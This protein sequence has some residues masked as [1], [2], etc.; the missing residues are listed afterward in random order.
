ML[1]LAF[2]ASGFQLF[3]GG[4]AVLGWLVASLA[5]AEYLRHESRRGQF[6]TF[7]VLTLLAV[8]GVFLAADFLTAFL[9]FELMSLLS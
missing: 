7:W 4:L 5:G 2:S 3:L 6:Y 1:P 9:F 8:L